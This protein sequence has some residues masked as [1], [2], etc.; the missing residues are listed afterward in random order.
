MN[1]LKVLGGLIM[2]DKLTLISSK[3][4]ETYDDMYKVIDFLNKNLK[5]LNVVFGLSLNNDK[6][7]ITLY[8]EK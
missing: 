2:D 7:V 1:S 6:Q 8:K 3:E 5:D 4:F